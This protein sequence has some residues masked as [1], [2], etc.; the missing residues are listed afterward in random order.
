MRHAAND[1]GGVRGAVTPD[2]RQGSASA[3]AVEGEKPLVIVR[4]VFRIGG[5]AEIFVLIFQPVLCGSIEIVERFVHGLHV[6]VVCAGCK[7]RAV[8]VFVARP[9]YY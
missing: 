3:H 7:C 8:P 6:G 2:A 4:R 9:C 5:S 1:L